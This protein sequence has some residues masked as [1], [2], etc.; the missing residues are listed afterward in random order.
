MV[1]N[2]YSRSS[3]S[4]QDR[5][6][7]FQQDACLGLF[8]QHPFTT[9]IGRGDMIGW[10]RS[11]STTIGTTTTTTLLLQS[12]RLGD[13]IFYRTKKVGRENLRNS[14]T[15]SF[16][17]IQF[18]TGNLY[19]VLP[20]SCRSLVYYM[21]TVNITGWLWGWRSDFGEHSFFPATSLEWSPRTWFRVGALQSSQLKC[22]G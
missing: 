5:L 12:K 20:A 19:W 18:S 11:R 10:R 7:H 16:M 22:K 13:E 8:T 14:V 17:L 21:L 4:S 3:S 15:L 1:D 6:F 2:N 9:F